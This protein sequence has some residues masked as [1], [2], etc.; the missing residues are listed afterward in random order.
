M[1]E[2]YKY[3]IFLSHSSKDNDFA[4]KLWTLLDK[5][6]F[7][8]WYDNQSLLLGTILNEIL[9]KLKSSRFV[10]VVWSKNA[11]KSQWVHNE[12]KTA[13]LNDKDRT[14]I[15]VRLDGKK[16]FPDDLNELKNIKWLDCPKG[17]LTPKDF[18]HILASIYGTSENTEFD[19]DVFV[20][21]S[22]QDEDKEVFNKY[23][24]T[25]NKEFRLIGDYPDQKTTDEQRIKKIM[26]TCCGYIALL[27]PKSNSDTY[28]Y[29]GTS[30]YFWKE[31]KW[32]YECDLPGLLIADPNVYSNINELKSSK[33]DS[34]SL[35]L[36]SKKKWFKD[37][38][39]AF[40]K[41]CIKA[42]REFKLISF[43][44]VELKSH[45]TEFSHNVKQ[46]QTP[47]I[48]YTK[49]INIENNEI[50]SFI[51]RL[52]GIVTAIPC[53][54]ESDSVIR[55]NTSIIDRIKENISKAYLMISDVS[56]AV[57]D[58]Y[59]D[60]GIAIHADI[61]LFLFKQ[62]DSSTTSSYIVN[63]IYNYQ[64]G[65]ECLALIHKILRQY[66][67]KVIVVEPKSNLTTDNIV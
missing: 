36:I 12:T 4:D 46:T 44:D 31:I 64:D 42:L 67:R 27:T 5:S 65:C 20:T 40:K 45:V 48:Y 6:G 9:D 59:V 25:L 53:K 19:K 43:D 39:N 60:I 49:N 61:E 62:Q 66:R 16:D 57:M 41:S 56:N 11:E 52:C 63:S 14:V 21:R 47:H 33:N 38:N 2:E 29:L 58:R 54:D 1:K 18:F 24:P 30:K 26:G 51:K 35:Q 37:E 55:V 28:T 3:D 17:S 34:Q 13:L 10:I 22:W 15:V 8:V 32:A 7:K 50:N 23:F